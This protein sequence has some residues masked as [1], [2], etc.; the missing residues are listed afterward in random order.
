MTELSWINSIIF[1]KDAHGDVIYKLNASDYSLLT[2]DSNYDAFGNG[3]NRSYSNLGYCGEYFDNE[4]G[5]IYLR[6]RYYNP[7]TGRFINE[8]PIRDG[9][10]WYVYCGN[11]PVNRWDPSGMWEDGDENLTPEAQFKIK[12]HTRM[13]YASQTDRGRERHHAAAEAIRNDPNNYAVKEPE[14]IGN[15]LALR[16]VSQQPFSSSACNFASCVSVMEYNSGVSIDEMELYQKYR[17]KMQTDNID[18]GVLIELA[19]MTDT[20]V[21]N[22]GFSSADVVYAKCV[23]EINKGNPVV[24]CIS[25]YTNATHFVV[26]YGY[27]GESKSASEFLAMDPWRT[28][29]NNPHTQQLNTLQDTMNMFRDGN[30]RVTRWSTLNKK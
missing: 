5:L 18:Y 3:G 23:E 12:V 15:P 13:Y 10:N 16:H 29:M 21:F 28:E 7:K 19:G 25:Y 4:S 11:N 20:I 1:E 14:A 17:E 30:P 9:L 22:S 8:D 6:A 2:Y 26:V 27:T 24:V